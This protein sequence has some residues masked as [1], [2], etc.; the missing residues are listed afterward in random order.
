MNNPDVIRS[1]YGSRGKTPVT[2]TIS[3]PVPLGPEHNVW[4]WNPNRIGARGPEP[5]FESR[6]R[7]EFGDDIG[8]TWNPITERWQ[9]F[10]RAPKVQ[11]PICQGWRLLFIHWGADHQFLPLDER[12]FG[13]IYQVDSSRNGGAKKYFERII[14]EYH[15]DEAKREVE[16]KQDAID[17][18][19]PYWEHSQ[20]KNIGKGSKFSTY[21]A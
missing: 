12:V 15:R 20:I 14:Q 11:T 13:R 10:A 3:K 1:V 5:S 2:Q 9:V 7:S 19:M 8:V 18:A 17:Q 16:K 21:H 6:L 4:F